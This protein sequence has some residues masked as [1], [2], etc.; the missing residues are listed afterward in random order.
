LGISKEWYLSERAF[1][2]C[3]TQCWASISTSLTIRIT[4][5]LL[6]TVHPVPGVTSPGCGAKKR[7]NF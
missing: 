5:F 6:Y 4:E 7:N 3:K 2:K 1:T